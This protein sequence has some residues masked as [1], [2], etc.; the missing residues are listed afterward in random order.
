[1]LDDAKLHQFIGQMLSDLGGAASVALVHI[2]DALGLYKALCVKGPMTV[3]ELAT[4]AGVH[5]RYL[6][7]WLSHQAASKYVSYDPAT[8]KFS[9]SP[10]QAMVFAIEDSPVNLIGAFETTAASLGNQELVKPAFKTGTGVR[11][12]TH[13]ASWPSMQQILISNGFDKESFEMR[14]LN[15]DQLRTF[16]EVVSRGNF[17][18]AGRQLNLT[19][20]AVSLHVRELEQRFG[21]RLVE[22][23][24]R[25]A[26]ATAPGR[27][28]VVHAQQIFR[29]S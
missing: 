28:L 14:S 4:E 1:M 17:S 29:D 12:E 20:P 16:V 6:R 26:Y 22:R 3:A 7:E 19:Q 10:E 8:Q 25:Q 27:E 18:A 21:V 15:L 13:F 23:V 9:L 5:Q 2:G 24:G 11:Y